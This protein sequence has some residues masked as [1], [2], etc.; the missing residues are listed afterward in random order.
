MSY[1]LAM[2]DIPL[3]TVQTWDEVKSSVELVN[4]KLFQLINEF[5]PK[6]GFDFV[7][8]RYHFGQ[9]I[10][11]NGCL[12]LPVARNQVVPFSHQVIPTDI[13]ERLNYSYV[14]IAIFLNKKAE[15]FYE[16]AERIMPTKIF[17]QGSM[18]GL[19]EMF[20]PPPV[21][22]TK[23]VWNITAGARSLFML[24]KISNQ[25]AHKKLQKQYK[26]QS[27]VPGN[28]M[29]HH[30]IFS[31]LAQIEEVSQPWS[32]DVLFF[33]KQW[34]AIKENTDE[35]SLRLSHFLLQEAWRQ[36]SNCRNNM[37]FDM[38]WEIFSNAVTKR[39]LKPKPLIINTLK[40]LLAIHDGFY[41]GYAPAVNDDA[42]PIEWL[43]NIYL[44]TYQIKSLPIIM[45]PRHLS[46]ANS[47]VYYSLQLPTLLEYAP[48]PKASNIITDFRELKLLADMLMQSLNEDKSFLEFFHSDE[49]KNID[50][51]NS[52]LLSALD[53]NFMSKTAVGQQ[54]NFATNNP[55][56]RGCIQISLQ[57]DR[58][59]P[60]AVDAV[61]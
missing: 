51:K 3:M 23:S 1:P 4:P 43:Q 54:L 47:P 33:S 31:E 61:F 36:S 25:V 19:W 37:S 35:K 48:G 40:H 46:K 20:D 32:M 11:K 41:P 13:Q 15:V 56:L 57:K 10:I 21:E 34:Q 12:Q 39:N 14:P 59:T 9:Y 45:E 7:R 55:F 49:D 5:Q 26:I 44:N 50:I 8:V 29:Q 2:K 58:S 16:S 22:F 60:L 18:F 53:C 27:Y 6:L 42:A 52:D 17:N 38:A 28:L 24:P 30:P